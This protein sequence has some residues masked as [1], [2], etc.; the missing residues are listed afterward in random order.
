MCEICRILK[1][2]PTGKR[3]TYAIDN[4]G[5]AGILI[6][7]PPIGAPEQRGPSRIMNGHYGCKLIKLN[8][9]KAI[10]IVLIRCASLRRAP[11]CQA[12]GRRGI[13]TTAFAD[14]MHALCVQSTTL[15]VDFV[16]FV[17]LYSNSRSG[18]FV[19]RSLSN[20]IVQRG[21]Q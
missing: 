6:R 1:V 3:L 19:S 16:Y 9:K 15:S 18:F 20:Y 5:P 13:S 8:L 7:R 14:F 21:H 12:D 10:N 2:Q 11:S 17:D 4:I